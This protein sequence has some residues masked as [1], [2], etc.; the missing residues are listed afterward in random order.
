[1]SE[2]QNESLDDNK[3]LEASLKAEGYV[4][5]AMVNGSG[6]EGKDMY[7]FTLKSAE[8]RAQ[9]ADATVQTTWEGEL[10]TIWVKYPTDAQM[11]AKGYKVATIVNDNHTDGRDVLES[12][13][14]REE[15]KGVDHKVTRSGNLMTLWVKD[16]P[17]EGEEK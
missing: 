13:I 3:A 11:E 15:S 9:K 6:K 2:T 10:A 5:E 4:M 16:G 7:E 14:A 1:M 17:K 8:E 12:A